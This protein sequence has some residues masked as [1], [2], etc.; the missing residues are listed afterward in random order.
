MLGPDI[1]TEINNLS[2]PINS[3]DQIKIPSNIGVQNY[4]PPFME[5]PQ[6]RTR[7]TVEIEK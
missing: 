2:G 6:R 4:Q 5:Q 1:N 3:E 7:H